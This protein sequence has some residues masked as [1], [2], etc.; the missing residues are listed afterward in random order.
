MYFLVQLSIYNHLNKKGNEDQEDETSLRLTANSL[1]ASFNKDIDQKNQDVSE[2]SDFM[3]A[4]LGNHKIGNSTPI[5][6]ID[7]QEMTQVNLTFSIIP[8]IQ[9]NLVSHSNECEKVMCCYLL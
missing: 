2:T 9:I 6:N 8:L 4:R 7:P 1:D 5:K 3:D